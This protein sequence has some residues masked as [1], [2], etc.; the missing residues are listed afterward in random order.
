MH[1]IMC[2]GSRIG[3]ENADEAICLTLSCWELGWG[4]VQRKYKISTV[5]ALNVICLLKQLLFVW[6]I[7]I[8]FHHLTIR[9][10]SGN[11]TSSHRHWDLGR[12]PPCCHM[13][14]QEMTRDSG[15]QTLSCVRLLH[16][17]APY[18]VI[19][20]YTASQLLWAE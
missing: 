17:W 2:V 5:H 20:T 13:V 11:V 4:G 8:K 19:P 1:C 10:C 14:M 3:S 16:L 9:F 7:S 6:A 15:C 18:P 12:N